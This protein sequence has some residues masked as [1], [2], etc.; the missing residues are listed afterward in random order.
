MFVLCFTISCRILSLK[1]IIGC[2]LDLLWMFYSDHGR[3]L[4]WVWNIPRLVFVI[5]D[6]VLYS[7]NIVGSCALWSWFACNHSISGVTDNIRRY[8]REIPETAANF[9]TSQLGQCTC[10]SRYVIVCSLICAGWGRGWVLQRVGHF[11]ENRAT[12]SESHCQ[13]E[14]LGSDMSRSIESI[15]Y[16]NTCWKQHLMTLQPR[17]RASNLA[18]SASSS[19]RFAPSPLPAL[20]PLPVESTRDV[21][22]G[23]DSPK[24]TGCLLA[25]GDDVAAIPM[26]AS[27]SWIKCE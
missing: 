12:R 1:E 15:N 11:V 16:R 7:K 27:V 14:D 8:T 18:C 20:S 17:R 26:G 10:L 24:A 2:S 5:L 22:V 3:N 19:V 25:S 13:S 9:N 21:G 6:Q 23:P 4:W